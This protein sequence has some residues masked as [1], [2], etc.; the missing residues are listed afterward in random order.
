MLK[1][2]FKIIA[3]LVWFAI[4]LSEYLTWSTL[5]LIALASIVLIFNIKLTRFMRTALA[6]G[7][8]ASYV[9]VYGKV[10][11]PEVG[12]NFLT[13]VVILKLLERESRRDQYMIFFGLILLFSAGSLFEKTLT[14]ACFYALAFGTLVYDF[15]SGLSIRWRVKELLLSVLWVLPLTGALFFLAPRVM[16]PMGFHGDGPSEGRVGY[17][18]D[19]NVAEIDELSTNDQPVFHAVLGKKIPQQNLYWR[20]NVLIQSD[21]WNWQAYQERGESYLTPLKFPDS[22]I[23][24]KIYLLDNNDFFFALDRPLGWITE[25][26]NMLPGKNE[27]ARQGRFKMARYEALSSLEVQER[28]EKFGGEYS[29]LIMSRKD[30]QMIQELFPGN[31]LEEISRQVREYFEKEGFSY[32]MTPGRTS[33]LREFLEKKTGFCAHYASALGIILRVK[34]I[35]VRLVSGFMGGAYNQFADYYLVTQNDAHVWVEAYSNGA[36]KRIDPTEWVAPLRVELGGE[37][38]MGAT[39]AEG[40]LAAF[41]KRFNWGWLQEARL[42]FNQW[43]F[44]FYRW[45]D[46]M[47]YYTQIH[48][49]S[50]LNIKKSWLVFIIPGFILAFLFSYLAF[51]KHWRGRKQKNDLELAWGLFLN[52]LHERGIH[53]QM[54]SINEVQSVMREHSFHEQEKFEKIFDD[55]V[56]ESFAANEVTNV[57]DILKELRSL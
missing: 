12:V 14:Y 19:L 54:V 17:S 49:L 30:K 8:F 16:G 21:G 57:K 37:A 40:P 53:P 39:A 1:P 46:E 38:F 45:L 41:G 28:N 48:L 33:G 55:L 36:W 15:Y 18:P 26:S 27:S 31:S 25:E 47:D 23:R 11:D 34:G 32:S 35:P 24:Q 13:S 5:G 52:K 42:W 10:I 56:R 22:A 9:L 29:S 43:D 51:L 2:E 50:Q 20:G 3:L 4:L 7:I 6:L 44:L